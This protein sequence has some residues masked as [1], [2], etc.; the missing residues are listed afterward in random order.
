MAVSRRSLPLF[1]RPDESVASFAFRCAT[2]VHLTLHDYCQAVLRLD[3]EQLYGD[4]D[5][6]LTGSAVEV[7]SAATKVHVDELREL[8]LPDDWARQTRKTGRREHSATV[9]ICPDCLDEQAGCARRSWRSAFALTCPTHRRFLI[10]QCPRC[11]TPIYHRD[12]QFKLH[13]LDRGNFCI[14]CR[15]RFTSGRRSTEPFLRAAER[16]NLALNGVAADGIEPGDL[17]RL[18][19]RLLS[20]IW[21]EREASA[22]T[23]AHGHSPPLA[24]TAL[25]LNA[26]VDGR[27]FENGAFGRALFSVLCGVPFS[28][29]E[30]YKGLLAEAM[31]KGQL[32]LS[33]N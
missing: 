9:L 21:D 2:R 26:M 32:S 12:H 23:G 16:W 1:P 24:M 33:L 10:D 14:G 7:L 13:W 22:V 5:D 8:R 15:Q 18:S 30:L 11:G 25:V 20:T 27:Y 6:V 3:H 19:H 31:P 4:L 28:S 17:A 29:R